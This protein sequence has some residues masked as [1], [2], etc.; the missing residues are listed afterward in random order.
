MRHLPEHTNAY[1]TNYLSCHL[2]KN[3][4]VLRTRGLEPLRLRTTTRSRAVQLS[5]YILKE[6]FILNEAHKT[7][8]GIV[9]TRPVISFCL[10]FPRYS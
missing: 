2:N 3:L 6:Q 1:F 7:S 9:Q 8:L 4:M 5:K 10:E